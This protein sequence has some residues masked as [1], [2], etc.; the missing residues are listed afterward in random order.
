MS[1]NQLEI[2][3]F[4]D[5]FVNDDKDSREVGQASEGD[6]NTLIDH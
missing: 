2:L 1:A 4:A 3:A 6:L 5:A